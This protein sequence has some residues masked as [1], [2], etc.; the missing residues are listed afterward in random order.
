[1]REPPPG[2]PLLWALPCCWR[3]SCGSWR[4]WVV[5]TRGLPCHPR[6]LPAERPAPPVTETLTW[7]REAYFSS[8]W[9]ISNFER[10]GNK[11]FLQRFP[12]S[13]EVTLGTVLEVLEKGRGANSSQQGTEGD[14]WSFAKHSGFI[15]ELAAHRQPLSF[16]RSTWVPAVALLS[17]V[18]PVRGVVHVARVHGAADVEQALADFAGLAQ[19]AAAK[20][21]ALTPP[22]SPLDG[23]YGGCSAAYLRMKYPPRG[24]ALAAATCHRQRQA[25]VTPPVSSGCLSGLRGARVLSVPQAR[26]ELHA[27][28]DLFYRETMNTAARVWHCQL[29]SGLKGP[30]AALVVRPDAF[31][32]LHEWTTH[33]PPTSWGIFLPTPRQGRRPLPAGWNQGKAGPMDREGVVGCSGLLSK[34]EIKGSVSWLVRLAHLPRLLPCVRGRRVVAGVQLL[35][36]LARL[37]YDI[38]LQ[39]Q[40][41][42]RTPQA[43]LGPMPRLGLQVLGVLG[44]CDFRVWGVLVR[45][46]HPI[47]LDPWCG[48]PHRLVLRYQLTF[49]SNTCQ[50]IFPDLPFTEAPP[51]VHAGHVGRVAPAGLAADQSAGGR[52]CSR[53]GWGSIPPS[54]LGWLCSLPLLDTAGSDLAPGPEMGLRLVPTTLALL[55][56]TAASSIISRN[57]DL[58]PWAGGGIQSNLSSSV[59]AITIQ[60]GAHH[61]DSVAITVAITCPYSRHVQS[62][63]LLADAELTC[64]QSELT[65]LL[66]SLATVHISGSQ[67]LFEDS[68]TR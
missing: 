53:R 19:G 28:Q 56:L 30:T 9:T 68:S 59:L 24:G 43:V 6:S 11:T 26:A 67:D 31:T 22:P 8:S 34:A 15:L 48:C 17:E 66:P 35:S 54:A 13:G 40:A 10:F 45:W 5:P 27:D 32:M 7:L 44:A 12:R 1:M 62:P 2:R 58:D 29:L 36:G 60:G 33:T 4:P 49:S 23:S 25:S 18:T 20:L 14:V 61:L 41:C 65:Q 57:G 39:Y 51:A 63:A 37:L 21:G 52:E 47:D 3:W 16:L 64:G 38:Y 42:V 55:D 50:D 46:S